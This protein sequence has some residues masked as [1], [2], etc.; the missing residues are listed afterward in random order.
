MTYKHGDIFCLNEEACLG[1]CKYKSV[2]RWEGSNNFRFYRIDLEDDPVYEEGTKTIN[3]LSVL[4][5][6]FD[7]DI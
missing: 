7:S 5:G 1:L 6:V 2:S 3:L 4:N